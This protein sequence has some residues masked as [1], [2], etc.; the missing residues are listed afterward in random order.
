MSSEAAPPPHAEALARLPVA[1]RSAVVAGAQTRWWEYG[2]A[3]A[4][5][6]VVA[7][8]GYR[9]DHHGLEPVVAQLSELRFLVPD[10]PGFG[11]SG[12]LPGRH[13][14]EAYADWLIAFVA[15]VRTGDAPLAVLGHS[16]GSIVVAAALD[17]GLEPDRVV[18]MNPIAAPAMRG[19]RALGTL[20]TLGWYRLGGALP[21]RAGR[22][23]LEARIMVDGMSALMTVTRDRT[24]RRWIREEHRR[25]FSGF[26]SR[27]SVIEGFEASIADS[28]SAHAAAFRVPTLL[29]AA[30]QDQITSMRD[31]RALHG[32]I[33]GAE[34]VV[35]DGVG[36]LVHY[37]R[38]RDAAAAIRAFLLGNTQDEARA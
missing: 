32:A 3:D 12:P 7:V 25:Y 30:A 21:E 23:A 26:H 20:A 16:F 33:P 27:D 6:A 28:V 8:H 24:L 5:I 38:P 37:E 2:A 35:I 19:P 36:H 11:A 29:I 34:L 17:R 9:G 1:A 14:V 15:A 18:L 31:V 13:T 4:A 10:L 22:R